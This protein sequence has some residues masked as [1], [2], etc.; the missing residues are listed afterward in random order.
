MRSLRTARG[1][2]SEAGALAAG[3]PARARSVRVELVRAIVLAI[4]AALAILFALPLL[5]GTS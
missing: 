2:R 1:R 4:I 5:L 3:V